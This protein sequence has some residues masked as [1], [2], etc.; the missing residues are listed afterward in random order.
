M[1]NPEPSGE[2]LRRRFAR[3]VVDAAARGF[4]D[5]G[6]LWHMTPREAGDALTAYGA[7]RRLEAQRDER[8]AWMIGYYTALAVHSPRRYP[9]QSGTTFHSAGLAM[10]EEEMK[11]VL[12]G[13]GVNADQGKG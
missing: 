9:K 13:M 6:R 1:M 5:P 11:R 10:S 12:R 3:I 8:L 2:S 4:P 7:A